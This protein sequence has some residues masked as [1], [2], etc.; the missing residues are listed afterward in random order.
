MDCKTAEVRFCETVC[1]L[2]GCNATRNYAKFRTSSP[3]CYRKNVILARHPRVVITHPARNR[4][5]H[6]TPHAGN[7]RFS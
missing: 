5:A 2:F 3:E 4:R 7:R 6:I 1:E